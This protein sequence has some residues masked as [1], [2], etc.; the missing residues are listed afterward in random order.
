MGGLTG[1]EMMQFIDDHTV[2]LTPDAP[3]KRALSRPPARRLNALER[4]V[5]DGVKAAMTEEVKGQLFLRRQLALA[6]RYA[7]AVRERN[8]LGCVGLPGFVSVPVACKVVKPG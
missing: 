4:Q 7:V 8:R 2:K 1:D 5:I 3:K 6:D